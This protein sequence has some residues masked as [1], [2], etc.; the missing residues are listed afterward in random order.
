M[1]SRLTFLACLL[2]CPGIL[3]VEHW[4]FQPL[5][6]GTQGGIDA[7]I[8]QVLK[9][10]GLEAAPPAEQH[11][12]VAQHQHPDAD[13]RPRLPGHGRAAALPHRFH[14]LHRP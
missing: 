3:A 2:T 11:Q 13:L 10:R 4:S 6:P 1:K 14:P 8:T 9:E 5:R 12:S 7:C